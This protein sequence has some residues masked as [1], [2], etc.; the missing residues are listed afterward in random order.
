MEQLFTAGI[1]LKAKPIVV[2]RFSSTA[3][4]S[5][6]ISLTTMRVC[7]NLSA[8]GQE[9]NTRHLLLMKRK[10]RLAHPH[11]K[12]RRKSQAA[13]L[14]RTMAAIAPSHTTTAVLAL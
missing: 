11:L 12:V 10:R 1:T 14:E 9:K 8:D 5:T 7:V 6:M 3:E 4:G 13:L 2:R